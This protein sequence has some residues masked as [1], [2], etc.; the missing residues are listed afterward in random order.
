M[1]TFADRGCRVVSVTDPYDRILGFLDR[2]VKEIALLLLIII[3]INRELCDLYSSPSRIT[4]IKSRRMRW[5]GHVAP[6]WGEE[7]CV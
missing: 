3:I 4:I 5:A 2:I 7:E 6:I 1:P